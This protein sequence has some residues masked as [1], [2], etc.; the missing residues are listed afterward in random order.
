M[1]GMARTPTGTTTVATT[2]GIA[3]MALVRWRNVL[4]DGARVL[5]LL[6]V[7]PGR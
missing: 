7:P 5:G 4:P 2:R 3:L 1:L 6:P